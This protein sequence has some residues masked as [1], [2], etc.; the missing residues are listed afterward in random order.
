MH[1]TTNPGLSELSVQW[2]KYQS[3][4]FWLYKVIGMR[5]L[6]WIVWSL[7]NLSAT[8]RQM[9]EGS[10]LDFATYMYNNL[11]TKVTM[12]HLDVGP[13]TAQMKYITTRSTM[14]WW[15]NGFCFLVSELGPE[16]SNV[17]PWLGDDD[18][19]NSSSKMRNTS[20]AKNQVWPWEAEWYHSD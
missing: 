16:R 20:P 7:W 5:N 10:F 3:R 1:S 18:F 9:R 12:C 14:S 8:W 6:Q 11:V 13:G 17:W 2:I 4:T 19:P 15:W